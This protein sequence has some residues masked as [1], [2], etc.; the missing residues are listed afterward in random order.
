MQVTTWPQQAIGLQS[1]IVMAVDT[2]EFGKD[3][4]GLFLFFVGLV[5]ENTSCYVILDQRGCPC[6]HLLS[7]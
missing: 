1:T 4:R 5:C 7:Q 6:R 2:M 3:I